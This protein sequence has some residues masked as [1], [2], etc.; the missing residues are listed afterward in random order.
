MNTDITPH[1]FISRIP[2]APFVLRKFKLMSEHRYQ[3]HRKGIFKPLVYMKLTKP[4]PLPSES[5]EAVFSCHVLEHLF[6]DEILPLIEEIKRILIPGGV[7]R[8]VVPDLEKVIGQF[9]PEKPEKF[10]KSMFET[11]T[12]DSVKNQH[13]TGFSGPYL[14]RLFQD[15]GYSSTILQ[16]YRVGSCP[17]LDQLDD[18]PE[19]SVFFEAIK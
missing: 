16:S 3:Q 8:V 18:R 6:Q 11:T 1:L 19:D 12:R 7:C 4:L 13:H 14:Q 5:V 15:A 9:D 17:N 10:L 2:L